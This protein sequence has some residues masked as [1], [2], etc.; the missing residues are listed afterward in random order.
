MKQG[1]SHCWIHPAFRL[2]RLSC[3]SRREFSKCLYSFNQSLCLW[4]YNCCQLNDRLPQALGNR[5]AKLNPFPSL[6]GTVPTKEKKICHP[7]RYCHIIFMGFMSHNRG[8]KWSKCNNLNCN[9]NIQELIFFLQ[10]YSVLPFLHSLHKQKKLKYVQ[11]DIL[12]SISQ[13]SFLI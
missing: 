12:L 10:H 9:T 3:Q 13:P 2:S 5:W 8:L 4:H 11:Y 7:L 1:P 6:T